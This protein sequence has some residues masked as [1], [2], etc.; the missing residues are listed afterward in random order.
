MAEPKRTTTLR[1]QRRGYS[2]VANEFLA[3]EH[4]NRE[5]F[6]YAIR[7]GEFVKVGISADVNARMQAMLC[8]NPFRLKLVAKARCV[9]YLAGHAEHEAHKRLARYHHRREWFVCPDWKAQE[10]VRIAPFVA[11][12]NVPAYKPG[13]TKP[14]ANFDP[15]YGG[16]GK[17]PFDFRAVG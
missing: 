2:A 16:Q 12:G 6:I 17:F 13:R 5:V 1:I 8:D 4:H 11:A 10:A 9:A 3:P 7:C 14:M 15:E